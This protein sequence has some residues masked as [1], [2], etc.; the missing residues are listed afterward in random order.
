MA[1]VAVARLSL[2]APQGRMGYA[3]QRCEDALR[4][5][6]GDERRLLVLRRLDL[7]SLPATASAMQ[8]EARTAE[9]LR[10]RRNRAVHGALAG[11]EAADA[12]WFHSVDEARALLLLLLAR[13]RTPSAWFWRLAVRDWKG[14]TPD[15]WIAVQILA[16][17][18]DPARYAALA[19]A[20]MAAVSAGD[21]GRILIW[22]GSSGMP[23]PPL[24]R[25][26]APALARAL[27][28]DETPIAQHDQKVRALTVIARLDEV[29]RSTLIRTLSEAR[30]QLAARRWLA[31]FGVIAA[32]SELAALPS[33]C[34]VLAE[35]LLEIESR[36]VPQSHGHAATAALSLPVLAIGKKTQSDATHRAIEPLVQT[37]SMNHGTMRAD[38]SQTLVEALSTVSY[39]NAASLLSP[40]LG[41]EHASAAA[42]VFLLIRPLWRM[43]LADWL[44]ARPELLADGWGRA[45]LAHIAARMRVPPEDPV[46][47]LLGPFEPV[48]DLVA[49]DAWRI[50][51]DRWLR[52][53]TGRR[54][55]VIARKR[56]WLFA[57]DD[58]LDVRFLPDAADTAL[59]RRALDLDPGWVDWL[60]LVVRYVYQDHR[61]Q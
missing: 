55:S 53:R 14:L 24:P 37:A 23:P 27:G 7:G 52:R 30:G 45:L 43:G 8:W 33:P 16:A 44:H 6:A 46:F 21:V 50:G 54:L 26:V 3:Q 22:L 29:T 51:V 25:A 34:A 15:R 39:D 56:G 47:A 9:R 2:A 42:G 40:A 5:V 48:E 12:V 4:L 38:E 31:T 28:R 17:R 57:R 13:G 11:A 49:L 18:H 35:A 60:G 1:D 19:R 32:A 58:G 41:A 59:R 20:M 10:E 36:A 61:L